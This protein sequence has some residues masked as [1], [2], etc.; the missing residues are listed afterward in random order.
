MIKIS[1]GLP[2]DV[3]ILLVEVKRLFN[4]NNSVIYTDT[5]RD[6]SFMRVILDCMAS[7]Q[8]NKKRRCVIR[9]AFM[10]DKFY[11]SKNTLTSIVNISSPY[12]ETHEMQ[13]SSCI[14]MDV[15]GIKPIS[16]IKRR[17][18]LNVEKKAKPMWNGFNLIDKDN[19]AIIEEIKKCIGY[20]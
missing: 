18:K 17:I 8:K 7:I 3:F 12:L 14:F 10:R 9:S 6:T 1:F 2:N 5:A 16:R 19:L 11:A 4:I 20:G 13:T 15:L